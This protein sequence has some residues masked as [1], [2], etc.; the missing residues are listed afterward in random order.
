MSAVFSEY[1]NN[2]VKTI[3]RLAKERKEI[4]VVADQY[5]CPTYAGNIAQVIFSIINK[6]AIKNSNANLHH[7][8]SSSNAK[9]I[10]HYCDTPALSWYEFAMIILDH[11]R[12]YDDLHNV[13]INPISTAEYPS[14]AQ[15]PLYSVLN[16]NKIMQDFHIHQAEWK[17]ALQQM[18]Q[19]HYKEKIK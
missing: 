5:T 10:Y 1:K 2:F 19:E 18:M 9:S 15:R 13:K 17:A 7:T 11:A 8:H 12:V 6:S 4:N 14:L 16:C 3:L